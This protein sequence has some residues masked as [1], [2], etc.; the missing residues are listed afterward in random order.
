MKFENLTALVEKD[1]KNNCVP[2]LVGDPGIGKS[3]WVESLAKRLN[4]KCF[5]LPV[6]QLA[7]K[8]D[9]TG[10]RLVPVGTNKDGEQDYAQMFY[11]HVVIRKAID[12]A[13]EHADETPILFLDEINRSTPDVTS[14][15]LSIPTLRSIGDRDIPDNLKVVIAGN[16][17]GNV[18]A[19]DKASITRF[20]MYHVEPDVSTFMSANPNL[21]K[22]VSAVLKKCP[23]S[24]VQDAVGITA[25]DGDNKEE[26]ESAAYEID[27]DDEN[28]EQMTVP[29]TITS[30][31]NWLNECTDQ[32]LIGMLNTITGNDNSL[33]YEAIVAHSGETPFSLSLVQEIFDT[34]NSQTKNVQ[35]IQ[36]ITL[37]EPAKY[38][39]MTAY[40]SRDDLNNFIATLSHDE[41]SEL[42]VYSLYDSMDN[43]RIL[44]CLAPAI[45]SLN[46]KD[47]QTLS[48]LGSSHQ[49]NDVNY[50]AVCSMNCGIAQVMTMLGF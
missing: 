28:M 2:M 36:N 25:N 6:N 22:Y 49:I 23:D 5:T 10:C 45:N 13:L 7:E 20:V 3:S 33:L 29:R 43:T 31:S 50:T 47:T 41:K 12:Y 42:F 48:L 26:A 24:I 39:E 14:E 21:N 37:T 4:T 38:Q 11:P 40:T 16:D 32:E 1:I 17:K 18:C 8:A 19:L 34:L 30:V 44:E 15:A 27:Y 35:Q 9:L 46:P